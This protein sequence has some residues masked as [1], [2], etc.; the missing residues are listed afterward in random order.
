M[1][2]L[3]RVQVKLDIH[4]IWLKIEI[5]PHVCIENEEEQNKP[6][7]PTWNNFNGSSCP[8]VVKQKG[9]ISFRQAQKLLN[10]FFT[11]M[12]STFRQNISLEWEWLF[13]NL[14]VFL[15]M[16]NLRGYWQKSYNIML[17]KFDTLFDL[18]TFFVSETN[19]RGTQ[20]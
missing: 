19:G 2:V 15:V 1:N 7:V 10:R 11:M 3:G 6:C 14:R 8:F 17:L 4:D 9:M 13:F 20:M 12:R 5:H 18:L 16:V